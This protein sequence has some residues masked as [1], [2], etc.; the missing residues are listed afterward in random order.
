VAY[1]RESFMP[2]MTSVSMNVRGPSAYAYPPDIDYTGTPPPD[3]VYGNGPPD[4]D[5][6]DAPH[7]YGDAPPAEGDYA[8]L[9]Q[10]AIMAT[11]RPRKPT[12]RGIGMA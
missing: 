4:G 11:L 10:T 5:Y 7:D 12:N 8:A 2:T 6:A 3:G 1:L 9:R